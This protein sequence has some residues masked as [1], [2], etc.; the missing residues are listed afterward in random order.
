MREV[1][2]AMTHF[3]LVSDWHFEAPVERV[4]ALIEKVEDW[5]AWWRAVKRVETIRE[6]GANG[7]GAVRRITW[8]TALPYTLTFDVEVTKIVRPDC[9][10]G[11]A[12]GEL[13][14]TGIWNFHD[15][16]E[17]THVR[18]FWRVEVTKPWMRALAPLL[19]RVFEWNHHQVMLWGL[20][21]ARKRLGGAG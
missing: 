5:P 17:G 4:W 3:S 16:P 12:F 10:E 13:E 7:V 21:G 19:E 18:Y 11:R 15:E 6:G 20:E 1:R 9:I 2:Q 14:G 8:A